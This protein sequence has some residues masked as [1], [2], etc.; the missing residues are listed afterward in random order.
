MAACDVIVTIDNFTAQ[1]AGSLGLNTKLLLSSAPDVRWGHKG[2]SCIWYN[3]VKI[4][5]QIN[6]GDW[7]EPLKQLKQD[8]NN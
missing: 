6:L 8:L 3:S 1:L 5:R 4:Y 2:T 7:S